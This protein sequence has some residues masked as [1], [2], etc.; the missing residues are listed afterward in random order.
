MAQENFKN[1][2]FY[3][4]Y[5]TSF[6]DSNNDGIGDLNGI[7]EKLPYLKDLGI[8]G[9]W[10][11]PFYKSPFL[12]G[13]YDIENFFEVDEK[14]GTLDDLK[15]LLKSAH[16]MG[17]KIIVD[18]V[19]GHASEAN[20]D[21]LE[22]AKSERNDKSDLFIWNKSVWDHEPGYRLIAG[23]HQRDGS[24][25]VNFFAH[26]PAFNYGF[27]NIEHHSWQ[28]YYKDERVY[29]AREYMIEV[30]RFYLNLGVDG[31]RVDMADSLVKNDPDK[32]ATIEVWR[33]MFKTIRS[34][35]KDAFF[36][37]EW[38]N[39]HQAFAA[40]FDCDFVLDHYDNF[41]HRLIR[42]KK[43]TRGISLLNGGDLSFFIQDLNERVYVANASNG[44]LGIISCNHDTP[45]P[46]NFIPFDRLKLYYLILFTIPGIPFIYYG[47]EIGM[48]TADI[49]SKDGGFQR[50][51][52]R[53][54]M[55]WDHSLNGG[56]SKTKKDT[57][58]PLFKGS[59]VTLEDAL[60]DKD[61]LYYFIKEL[62][63]LKKNDEDLTSRDYDLMEYNRV[64]TIKRNN[65]KL[66]INLSKEDIKY[67]EET[68]ISTGKTN[69]VLHPFEG[70][71]LKN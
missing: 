4:I 33:D 29:K 20:K 51:G 49:A 40:G 42:S 12:D 63:A 9:V 10:I 35:Y 48:K 1:L 66:V 31:F 32:S 2:V 21:F 5:P 45:R 22:S 14:F 37:A 70:A 41:Y 23:R 54:P 50:T 26:Q 56:F 57:Y 44:Y 13:G 53:T 36:V 28:I 25:M 3:E 68:V 17:I 39:P 47:D 55:Q 64:I 62:I 11:N 61:S 69:G 43:E 6:Y 34:E 24:F 38:S 8:N 15:E 7:K 46:A 19:P 16:Q 67:S 30:M 65:K 18:L 27:N 58:L 59:D 52:S 71:L 60:K